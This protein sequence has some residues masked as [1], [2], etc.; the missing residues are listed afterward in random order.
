M[1][2][3]SLV[4]SLVSSHVTRLSLV[5]LIAAIP[6]PAAQ[7]GVIP[8]GEVQ[9]PVSV[10]DK[11]RR[12]VTGL[13]A[14]SFRV[15]EDGVEQKVTYFSETRDV[16]VT[17]GIILDV[18][19]S[20]TPVPRGDVAGFNNLTRLD[21]EYFLITFAATTQMNTDF[22]ANLSKLLDNV[23]LQTSRTAVKPKGN[24]ALYDAMYAG[25]TKLEKASRRQR[26]LVVIS[27]AE[28]NQSRYTL[29]EI[30]DAFRSS[31]AQVFYAGTHNSLRKLQWPIRF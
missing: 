24:T 9:I 8:A 31:N 4:R 11:N 18:S 23:G 1:I 14:K 5:L 10:T 2:R 16:P 20:M 25:L 6:L 12:F 17:L 19:G 21:D 28:D 13:S 15:L 3:L 22:S 7:V 26:A 30:Q 27:D 29:R